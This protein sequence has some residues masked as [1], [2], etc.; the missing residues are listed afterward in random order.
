MRV[1]GPESLCVLWGKG[2]VCRKGSEPFAE[3]YLEPGGLRAALSGKGSCSPEWK[4]G[5][6]GF[7]TLIPNYFDQIII[8]VFAS[9]SCLKNGHD[10]ACPELFTEPHRSYEM[11]HF[12]YAN[13]Q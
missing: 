4:M 3:I 5:L 2:G 9:V 6:R 12:K 7:P 8:V 10:D 13:R 11:V 1:P